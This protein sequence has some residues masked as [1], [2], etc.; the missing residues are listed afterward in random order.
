[1][2]A[3]KN[4]VKNFVYGIADMRGSAWERRYWN[5]KNKHQTKRY[6]VFKFAD[7]AQAD[8]VAAALSAEL[9]RLGYDSNVRRTSTSGDSMYCVYPAEYVRVTVAL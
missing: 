1:M 4:T 2:L 3:D 5:D 6:L 9:N 8:N 7:A